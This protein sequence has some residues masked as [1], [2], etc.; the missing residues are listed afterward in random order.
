MFYELKYTIE[1][2]D[3]DVQVVFLCI[4]VPTTISFYLYICRNCSFRNA[5]FHMCA[6][7]CMH[8]CV[9]MYCRGFVFMCIDV[10]DIHI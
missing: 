3:L 1:T 7:P 9:S 5:Y 2:I 6:C 4:Y 10:E 8:A